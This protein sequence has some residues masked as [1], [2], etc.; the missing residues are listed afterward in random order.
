MD[1]WEVP[2]SS[3]SGL[4]RGFLMDVGPPRGEHFRLRAHV[5]VQ[6]ERLRCRMLHLIQAGDTAGPAVQYV[7]RRTL[8]RRGH[9][10]VELD[11]R[12]RRPLCGPSWS[13]RG[14]SWRP[15]AST[16]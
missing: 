13:G 3:C 12:A 16:T 14:K 8:L 11:V 7:V 5:E 4:D 6:R 1:V 10:E 9:A 15:P 2:C